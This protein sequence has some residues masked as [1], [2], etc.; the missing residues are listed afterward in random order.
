[1]GL[2]VIKK[3]KGGLEPAGAL[4][5]YMAFLKLDR[6]LVSLVFDSE[7]GDTA[8][9]WLIPPGA[10]EPKYVDA[11]YVRTKDFGNLERIFKLAKRARKKAK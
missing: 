10:L 8:Q 4:V 7:R 5:K 1:M 11:L 9:L 3:G 2:I 6:S